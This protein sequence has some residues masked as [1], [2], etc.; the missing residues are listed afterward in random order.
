MTLQDMY[1]QE[2]EAQGEVFHNATGENTSELKIYGCGNLHVSREMHRTEHS[3]KFYYLVT[4][5]GPSAAK[6]PRN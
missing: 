5:Y 6:I 2:K 4:D 3:F 1:T